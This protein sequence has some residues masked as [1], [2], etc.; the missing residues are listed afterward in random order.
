V[1]TRRAFLRTLAGGLL[2]TPLAAVAQQTA[3]IARIGY[4]TTADLATAP[5]HLREAFFKGLRDLGYVEGRN[6]VIE[7]RSAEGK[8]ERL[9]ALAAELVSLKVDVILAPASV[10]VLAAKQATSHPHCLREFWRSG[11]EWARHQP[12]ATGR[13]CHGVVHPHRGPNK[14]VSGTDPPGRSGGQS[15]RRPLESR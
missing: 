5:H 15:G 3:K 1:V 6:L 10:H 4:L 12:C 8:V 7:Y 2:G 11:C 14:Q 9:P 13:Q